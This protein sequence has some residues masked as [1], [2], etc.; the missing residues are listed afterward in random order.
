MSRFNSR[1]KK[2]HTTVISTCTD[3]RKKSYIMTNI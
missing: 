2:Q 1:K 3:T